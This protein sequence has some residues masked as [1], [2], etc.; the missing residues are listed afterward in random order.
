MKIA[1]YNLLYYSGWRKII[2][3]FN[4]FVASLRFNTTPIAKMHSQNYRD[5]MNVDTRKN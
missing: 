5:C 4:M 3:K 1:V 2:L